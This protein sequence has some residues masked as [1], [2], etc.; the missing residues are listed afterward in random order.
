MSSFISQNLTE[1]EAVNGCTFACIC[2]TYFA[3][4]LVYNLT[5]SHFISASFEIPSILLADRKLSSNRGPGYYH[6]MVSL[7]AMPGFPLCLL[8]SSLT[9]V[10]VSPSKYL[11]RISSH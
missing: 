8:S 4:S 5:G 6:K 2:H 1:I 11:T 9:A 3:G 10:D 7:Q